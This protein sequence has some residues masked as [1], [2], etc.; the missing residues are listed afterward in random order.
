VLGVACSQ[1]NASVIYAAIGQGSGQYTFQR[2]TNAGA[3][4]TVLEN[5]PHGDLCTWTC[6]LLKAHPLNVQRAFRNIAC[7]AGRNVPGGLPLQQ[8]ADQGAT[9][10]DIFHPL[11]YPSRL[12]GGWGANRRRFY[13]GAYLAA[14]PGGGTYYR[15][16]D[17][18]ATWSAILTLGAGESVGGLAYHPAAPDLVYAGLTSGVVKSSPDGGLSW[19]DLGHAGLGGIEDLALSNDQGILFAA[20]NLGVW[21]LFV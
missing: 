1:A 18:A 13:L 14:S 6:F 17:D 15:S 12:V 3:T 16:D 5:V 21:R 9:W 20:S 2:S 7:V 8:T 10:S 11:L 4:W 19:A